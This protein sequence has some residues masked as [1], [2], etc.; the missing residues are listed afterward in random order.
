M[1][2]K[3]LVLEKIQKIKL[4][5]EDLDGSGFCFCNHDEAF[6]S[7]NQPLEEMILA[8]IHE[9]LHTFPEYCPDYNLSLYNRRQLDLKVEGDARYFYN[10]CPEIRNLARKRILE[11]RWP[12]NYQMYLPFEF[13]L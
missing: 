3:D 6:I 12:K 9:T 4:W 7:I 11:S 1:I 2:S 13:P 10:N 8:L 5:V